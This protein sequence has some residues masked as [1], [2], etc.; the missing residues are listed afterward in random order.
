MPGFGDLGTADGGG[1]ASVYGGLAERRKAAVAGMSESRRAKGA[2][3]Q[4]RRAEDGSL[5]GA[6]DRKEKGRRGFLSAEGG[7][8]EIPERMVYRYRGYGGRR[9]NCGFSF[10]ACGRRIQQSQD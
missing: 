7:T 8:S 6:E 2:F 5:C 1:L 10:F 3:R 9:S 4:E